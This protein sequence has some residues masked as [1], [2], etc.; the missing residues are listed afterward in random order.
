LSKFKFGSFCICLASVIIGEPAQAG[1][2]DDTLRAALQIEMANLDT[3]Y[4]SAGSVAV[5]M[6]HIWDALYYIDP[7]TSELRPSLAQGHRFLDETTLEID[8]RQ[9]VKFH[10]GQEMTA[11]DVVYTLNWI[12]NPQNKVKTITSPDWIGLAERIDRYKVRIKLVEPTAL[13]LRFLSVFPIYPA[14]T[15]DKN[16]IAAMNINPVGTGPYKVVTM[17]VGKS[18]TLKRFADHFTE[19]PKGQASIEN[20]IVRIVPDPGTQIAEMIRGGLD[21]IYMVSSDQ[22]DQLK[23][24]KSLIVES[25]PTSRMMYMVMDAAGKT[26]DNSP[27]KKTLVRKAISHAIDREGIVA[28]LVQGGS[29]VLNAFCFPQDFGC[30][31]DVPKYNYDP[32]L[33]KSMLLEA[34]Y[35]NGFSITLS[36]WRDRAYVEAIIGNLNAIGIKTTLN[37]SN[38]TPLRE[39]WNK[40]EL[41][42]IYGSIGSQVDDVGNFT[43]EFFGKSERDLARDDEVAEWLRMANRSL[44]EATRKEFNY[45][46]LTKVASEAYAL[47]LFSDNMNS[48]MSQNLSVVTDSG[49]APHFY[50]AKWK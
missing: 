20:L 42:L 38:L 17:E 33:A 32:K 11:D 1:K 4:E 43:P 40:G 23:R 25:K 47:P 22:A 3:Y 8:L 48:V 15:Y 46:A 44:D 36:A 50:R 34:G 28:A 49:G 7:E 41:P 10:N 45:K 2:T 9:G 27:F 6:R 29:K 14:G 24:N 31:P 19:S 18:Y 13:A 16:G 12:R 5:L 30:P 39:R 21:W 26:G 35:P 37:Y